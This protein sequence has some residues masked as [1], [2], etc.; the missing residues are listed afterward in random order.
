[1]TTRHGYT[2]TRA[3][4]EERKKDADKRHAIYAAL[5]RKEKIA[6]C[7]S[8]RGESRRERARLERPLA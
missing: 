3:I 2:F 7:A 8:R 4:R 1:M 5:S 6:L